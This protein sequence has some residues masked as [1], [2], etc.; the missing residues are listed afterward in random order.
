MR[1]QLFKI[2]NAEIFD[3]L[4][5]NLLLKRYAK[6]L[7]FRDLVNRKTR[8]RRVSIILILKYKTVYSNPEF[9]KMSNI[10]TTTLCNNLKILRCKTRNAEKFRD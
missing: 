5:K 9:R 6:I 3:N 4:K 10:I 7:Q 8:S 2:P 1:Q